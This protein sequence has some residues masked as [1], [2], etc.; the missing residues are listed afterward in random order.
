[1]SG[2]YE[3]STSEVPGDGTNRFFSSEIS[4]R[5]EA[6]SIVGAGIFVEQ[7]LRY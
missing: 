1:M 5:P 7:Q 3:V 2:A 4:S 6:A